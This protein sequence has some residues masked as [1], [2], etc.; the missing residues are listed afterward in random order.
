MAGP[1]RIEWRRR[2][3][4]RAVSNFGWYGAVAAL[5]VA[6]VWLLFGGEPDRLDSGA[7]NPLAVVPP[8]V[9]VAAVAGALVMVVPVLRWPLVAA[10]HY[11]LLVR[12][13][14]GRMLSLPWVSVAEISLVTVGHERYLLVRCR[15]DPDRP[16]D[17]PSRLDRA[18]LRALDRRARAGTTDGY[19][20]AVPM[21][22]FL[23]SVEAQVTA[24]AAFAPDSVT[25]AGET[26]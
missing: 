21:R 17:R 5:V 8:S 7:S 20:L 14:A 16:G 6:C 22:D 12:T 9:T 24:L 26:Y 23:G 15:P 19:D 2:W 11:A 1:R 25:F 18:P 13:G 4:Q 10:D 3:P